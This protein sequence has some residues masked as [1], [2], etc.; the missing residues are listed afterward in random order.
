MRGDGFAGRISTPD[1]GHQPVCVTIN[2][3]AGPASLADTQS[4]IERSP[5][6]KRRVLAMSAAL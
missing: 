2:P 4:D 1:T 6:A 5:G 3:L